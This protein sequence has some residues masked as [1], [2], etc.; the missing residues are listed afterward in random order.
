[1]IR[2]ESLDYNLTPFGRNAVCVGYARLIIIMNTE[3][4]RSIPV[5]VHLNI[6]KIGFHVKFPANLSLELELGINDN[7]KTRKIHASSR[8]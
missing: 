6:H 3:K 4:M 1:M 2:F 7:I 5:V 8:E